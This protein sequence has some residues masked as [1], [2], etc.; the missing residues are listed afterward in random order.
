M[1]F[2]DHAF[3]THDWNLDLHERNNHDR[4]REVADVC[5]K[6]G[7]KVWF[8]ED[9][10]SGN[11]V[12]KMCDGIDGSAV[13]VVFVTKNYIEKVAQQ[14]RSDDNCKLEF[15]YALRRRKPTMMIAVVME[16]KCRNTDDWRGAVGMALGN[17]LYIDMSQ[18]PLP[19][20]D[21]VSDLVDAI[22]NLIRKN[23][24]GLSLDDLQQEIKKIEAPAA[25]FVGQEHTIS[26]GTTKFT[27]KITSGT[28][29][30]GVGEF[31]SSSNSGNKYVGEFAG[32]VPD[33][34][35]I[36]TFNSGDVYEGEYRNG[37]KHGQGT[38]RFT[39]GAV[40]TGGYVDGKKHGHG[41]Y[42]ASNGDVYDG[43]Y[44]EGNK[45]GKG[46][47][48]Y[49][50]GKV[51][52]GLWDD[53]KFLGEESVADK[54]EIF[55]GSTKYEGKILAG[56]REH[57]LGEFV[58]MEGENKGNKY[59]GIF[60]DTTPDNFGTFTFNSGET[61]TGSYQ[62][63]KKNGYGTYKFNSGAK[64]E[65]DYVDGKKN[66]Y[67]VY[68]ASNGDVFEGE[69]KEGTKEGLGTM[70]YKS[71]KVEQGV[72]HDDKYTGLGPDAGKSHTI[73]FGSTSFEGKILYGSKKHGVGDFLRTE[74][75][76]KGNR[77]VGT[78]MDNTPEGFGTFYYKASGEVYAG[79]YHNGRKTGNGTYTF[80]SGAKYVG[81]YVDGQKHGYGVYKDAKGD[82]YEGEY[83]EGK[84]N[85]L[86]TMTYANGKVESGRFADDRMMS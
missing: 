74:G 25:S 28:I 56:N 14:E 69:Y 79:R 10:M 33:G 80:S 8:D 16:E 42:K 60:T 49:A 12:D 11:I 67:G 23:D 40:Y 6:R 45:N 41:V 36:F 24:D 38:Y 82:T 86:G 76:S 68:H 30:K 77:Y 47:M 54:H 34:K 20:S 75:D 18:G 3:F 81:G 72:W 51:E 7:L 35:G 43:D 84:K 4:V 13:V 2:V 83:K 48:R 46:T 63:G 73:S 66:G 19:K 9:K 52:K 32:S 71:G 27:G 85:G 15:N 31:Y 22:K 39:S 61:Y 26:F 44:K 62:R 50:S 57:G 53:D 29:E 78:F 55:F 17:H 65:G 21:K 1:K 64:Y 5:K 37:R 70:K 59:H 58:R